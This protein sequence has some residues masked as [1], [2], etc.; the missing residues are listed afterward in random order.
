MSQKPLS[1][2][3]MNVNADAIGNE[4]RF[5]EVLMAWKPHAI[6]VMNR[7]NGADPNNMV[8]RIM[9]RQQ[10]WNGIVIY[11]PYEKGVEGAIWRYRSP[12]GHI[13]H[14]LT[15]GT[16]EVWFEVGNEP[17]PSDPK[18]VKVMCKWYRDFAKLAVEY[19]LRVVFPAFAT[20]NFQKSEI[21]SG[22]IDDL[23]WAVIEHAE[24]RI[25]GHSQVC[26]DAHGYVH[27]GLP[28]HV[29]GQDPNKLVDS[30][31]MQPPWKT[32]TDIFDENTADNWLLTRELWMWE[33]AQKLK[34]GVLFDMHLTEFAFDRMPNIE[35][36]FPQ[37]TAKIDE[38]AGKRIYGIP[39][40]WEYWRKIWPQWTPPRALCEQ[41]LWVETIYPPHVKSF[42]IFTWSVGTEWTPGYNI[43]DATEFLNLWPSYAAKLQPQRPPDEPTLPQPTDPRW[44]QY[45]A[46]VNGMTAPLPVRGLP[47]APSEQIG[48]LGVGGV[49]I[50]HIPALLLTEKERVTIGDD[51][52]VIHH[53]NFGV[54]YVPAAPVRMEVIEEPE[55]EPPVVTI[56]EAEYAELKALA[57]GHEQTLAAVAQAL[58]T[59]LNPAIEEAGQLASK[60][61]EN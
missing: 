29:D 51:W 15:F 34:P 26:L 27:G 22:L 52:L 17:R 9:Y 37:L 13:N 57:R 6:L 10:Q 19:G 48:T 43:S 23:L 2:L 12:Q 53:I 59:I 42:C 20:G 31:A 25:N 61:E 56:P 35:Q 5:F 39:T 58:E 28:V 24:R 18:E 41:F 54:G 1:R 3:S 60:L 44:R 16:K 4:S 50:D 49:L 47:S 55:P 40:L 14:L 38:M 45:K 36:Q 7:L 21:D 11:R 33:R 8:M 46:Y 30:A 32:A